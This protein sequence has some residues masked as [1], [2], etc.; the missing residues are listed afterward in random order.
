MK[1]EDQEEE[2]VF[3]DLM[4]L[5]QKKNLTRQRKMQG[6][7][8]TV[9]GEEVG[10]L[11]EEDEK[12]YFPLQMNFL[13]LKAEWMEIENQVPAK[14]ILLTMDILLQIENVLPHC[15]EWIWPHYHPANVLGM[16]DREPLTT[17]KWKCKLGIQ[18]KEEKESRSNTF[19]YEVLSA[20]NQISKVRFIVPRGSDGKNNMSDALANA[21]C[22]RCRA[23]FD[24]TERIFEGRKYC[25]HDFQML[26]APCCGECG[27]FIIGRVIKA[28][29]NNWHPECFCCELCDVVL[30]D[31]GFVKNA[32]R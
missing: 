27:E 8:I 1:A 3:L 14:T 11:Q 10:V 28:M 22:E 12:V 23:R 18:R 24:P 29:N 5:C 16:M 32:G 9:V 6:E 13:I 7:E 15:K 25:E 17:E 30:A 4:I 31:L 19:N 21:V 26:F 2:T 20:E